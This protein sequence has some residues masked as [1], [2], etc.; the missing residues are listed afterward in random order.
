MELKINND[1]N[2]NKIISKTKKNKANPKKIQYIYPKKIIIKA[3]ENFLDKFYFT[4]MKKISEKQIINKPPNKKKRKI[5]KTIQLKKK[6][7]TIIT[8]YE[9]KNYFLLIFCF[10]LI[11][12]PIFLSQNN[13]YIKKLNYMEEITIT[14][15]GPGTKSIF[16]TEFL[17]IPDKIYINGEEVT[18][19]NS[20]NF[21]DNE[22][23][24][25]VYYNTV[26]QSLRFMF[27]STSGIT[28]IDLTKFDTSNVISMEGM[29]QNCNDLEYLNINGMITS[30]VENMGY[31]FE[32]CK[33]IQSLD[34][35]SFETSSVLNMKNMFY[36]CENLEY[37]DISNFNTSSVSDMAQMFS[38]C[39]KIESID[40]S[41]FSARNVNM[42][43]MFDSCMNL[44]SIKFSETKKIASNNMANMF[45]NCQVLTS[46]DLSNFDTSRC[47]NMEYLFDNCLK[48]T[49]IDLSSF[50]TSSVKSFRNMFSFCKQ[51]ESLDLSHFD[52]ASVTDMGYMLRYCTKLVFLNL[53]SFILNSDT[54]IYSMFEGFLSSTQLCY[55][56]DNAGLIKLEFVNLNNNCSK[57]CFSTN[58]KLIAESNK[59]IN[60]CNSEG[61]TYKYEYKN[62]CY[63]SCPEG[64]SQSSINQYLCI[65]TLICKHYYNIDKSKCFDTIVEGYFLSDSQ[66]NIL[67]KCHDYCKTCNQ[68]ETEGNTN[69]LTCKDNYYFYKGNCF[70]ECPYNFY[71]DNLNNK[72]C[73]CISNIKCKECSIENLNLCISCNEGYFQKYE[74]YINGISFF[75]CYNEL[76]KYYLDNNY[77]YSCFSLCKK[78]S[79]EGNNNKHNCDECIDNYIFINEI[80]KK[81]NCYIKCNYYYYFDSNNEYRCTETNSCTIEQNKL[82]RNKGKCIDKC[83][84]DDTYI[85]EYN[86]ECF[87]DCPENTINENNIC[88]ENNEVI[89]NKSNMNEKEEKEMPFNSQNIGF[90]AE[91][92]FLGLYNPSEQSRIKKDDVIKNIR[93]DIINHNLDSIIS[94]IILERQDTLITE[95]N[96]LFQITT[97]ANQKNN[98]YTNISTIHLGDC[99]K[100]LKEKYNIDENETLIIFKIDYN[101]TGL[102]IPIIGYD[103]FHPKNKTK[104]DLSYCEQSSINYNIPVTIN[105]DYL[106]KYNPNSEYYSD[107]CNTYTTENGTD[108]LLND[109][110]K[111]FN[112]KNMSLC[113]NICEYVGYDLN[114]KKA[115]C[116]CGIRYKEFI[117]SEL[118]KQNDLLANNFTSDNSSSNIG[119]MKCYELLFSKDGLLTNIGSYI[120]LFIIAFH[121]ISIIIFYK[122]GYHIINTYIEDILKEKINLNKSDMKDKSKKVKKNDI[123]NIDKKVV[124]PKKKFTI[125]N[126]NKK[127]PH[128]SD[129]ILIKKK[130]TNA[131]PP[132]RWKKKTTR[133]VIQENTNISSNQKSYTKLIIKDSKIPYHRLKK[134]SYTSKSQKK[135]NN[136]IDDGKVQNLNFLNYNDLEL[137]TMNYSEALK[138]DK[139]TFFQYY[140][141]LLKTKHPLIFP[142]CQQKDYNIF[143]IKICLFFLIFT[144]YYAINTLFFNYTAIHKIYIDG[145][146][147]NISFFF[148]QIFFSFI[149]SY[150]I[151]I[152]IQYFSLSERNL[153][154]LKKANIE[155]IKDIKPNIERCITIKNI[156]Y[157]VI[158]IIFLI[159]FWYYLSSFCAVYQNS[160]AYLFINTFISFVL[161]LIYSFFINL[162]PMFLRTISLSAKNRESVYKMSK[163]FQLL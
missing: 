15:K 56:E 38:F 93:E 27:K 151:N 121:V 45:I 47:T 50:N 83:I 77:F 107:D 2:E 1:E 66:Q 8:P 104:L 134:K 91:N 35:S 148:P 156:C 4:K 116:Q 22:N 42:F 153:L 119:T 115:L 92:F 12:L 132:R 120:L 28:K 157:F 5:Q 62:K 10:F 80:N 31:M 51:L 95:D 118:D 3:S 152:I 24:I 52:T 142:F 59:C 6:H 43:K 70:E 89:T 61:N 102:L 72:I 69:C 140:L 108:I 97:S 68:K 60:D 37:L 13:Y 84:N 75:E 155:I 11:F 139:R 76:E 154:E 143:I 21:E 88:I 105:E 40:L 145:G 44:K 29:F 73:T 46:L 49:L 101:I 111:E 106:F 54:Y 141:S 100:T 117:L 36:N 158:S 131:M 25:K 90:S 33:K 41:S 96:T 130:K 161:G 129:K 64:T 9:E 123:Y 109:R 55:N 133:T 144:V 99:E 18:Y 48:L 81:K 147:Y 150:H 23:T 98:N 162:V 94:N 63:Y 138:I 125:Y 122:C 113:E 58:S 14:I 34:L 67:D 16:S 20:F 53:N 78:C 135:G 39:K 163:I 74:D 19:S 86:N 137:N 65:K 112:E 128:K 7:L 32:N 57:D 114:N 30:S 159:L 17:Q 26:P 71:K 85:N 103:V 160:Q 126:L 82:I 146:K 87:K 149:I 110:K 136:K 127:Q 79:G 124:K